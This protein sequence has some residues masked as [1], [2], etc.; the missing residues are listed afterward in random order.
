M[1]GSDPPRSAHALLHL[2]VVGWIN[3]TLL[4]WIESRAIGRR[5]VGKK[6][7]TLANDQTIQFPHHEYGIFSGAAYLFERSGTTWNEVAK[8]TASDAAPERT[9]S[10]SSFPKS[11]ASSALSPGLR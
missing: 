11:F 3:R 4:G 6:Q 8:L 1:D 9:S 5:L 2:P 7:S 10:F